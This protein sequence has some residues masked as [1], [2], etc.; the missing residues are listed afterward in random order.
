MQFTREQK[1]RYIQ[2]DGSECPYCHSNNIDVI[3][4]DND[5]VI[6]IYV[7]CNKCSKRWTEYYTLTDI[8]EEK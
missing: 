4:R 2:K 1:E 6:S 7:L 3:S 8:E 5:I